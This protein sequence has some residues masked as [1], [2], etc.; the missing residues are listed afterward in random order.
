MTVRILI[1]DARARLAEL[2]DCSVQTC[3][4]SPPYF[5]LRDYGHD[6]QMGLEDTPAAYVADLV[7][8]LREVRRV[9]RPDGTLWL[10]L[11]DSYARSPLKGGSGAGGKNARYLGDNYETSQRRRSEST[12]P[13]ALAEKQLMGI[14]WRVA[15]ALQDDG[16]WLRQ[17]IIWSKPNPMPESVEDR[18]TK[19]HEYLF[20]LTKSARYHFDA[21]AIMEG[22]TDSSIARMSQNLEAQAGSFKVPGKTNGAIKP[23]ARGVPPR[24]A[25]YESSDQSGLDAVGR[26]GG[27]NKRSVWTIATQPL[28]LD[29][30]TACRHTYGPAE[31]RRLRREEVDGGKKP[32][33]VWCECGRHDAWLSHFATF[34]PALVEPCVLA[35]SRPGDTVLDPFGGAGTTGMVAERLGRD[36]VLI[37]LNPDYAELARTR[38]RADRAR[39]VSDAPE[40]APEGRSGPLFAVAS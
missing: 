28:G 26:G 32:D 7:G 20:L 13:Q 35:G 36:A 12:A 30:C 33:R 22:L 5:G 24:H 21:D 4:T 10:N 8:L 40:V 3:V 16:W 18:C 31:Y 39:V 34:P 27:R 15:F 14:P 19:A 6:G 17:D 37:E 1:G 25:Q 29:L 9:L 23:R 38:L 2:P 11:G